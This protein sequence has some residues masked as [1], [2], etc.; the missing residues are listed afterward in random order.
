MQP[1]TATDF[2]C[3]PKNPLTSKVAHD[4][5]LPRHQLRLRFTTAIPEMRP[6]SRHFECAAFWKER[7]RTHTSCTGICRAQTYENVRQNLIQQMHFSCTPVL[8]APFPTWND[9][10]M[11]Q[12][13]QQVNVQRH[14]KCRG[15]NLGMTLSF[16]APSLFSN[17]S[18]E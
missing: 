6:A 16:T 15:S 3:E 2:S 14:G 17:C 13:Y 11:S 9:K 8:L 10:I 4:Q 12:H 7:S 1:N 5:P 18:Q